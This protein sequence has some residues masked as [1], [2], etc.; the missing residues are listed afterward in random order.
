MAHIYF[1]PSCDSIYPSNSDE[2]GDETAVE[3]N[4]VNM[5]VNSCMDVFKTSCTNID[6]ADLLL[7]DQR[8][9]VLPCRLPKA[10]TSMK[11]L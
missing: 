9:V 3:L 11:F 10:G 2:H 1:R 4:K 7:S 5:P 6:T 8:E